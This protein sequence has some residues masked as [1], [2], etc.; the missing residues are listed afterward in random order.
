MVIRVRIMAERD[1][2]GLIAADG[3]RWWRRH[4]NYWRACLARQAAG[5]RVAL[6]ATLDGRIAG[7]A[8]LSWRSQYPAFQALDIPEIG[9]L[10]VGEPYRRRGVG[11]A[12]I[13]RC[14]RLARAR[15]CAAIGLGVGLYADYGSAQRLYIRLGYAL[16]GAGVTYAN[17]TL[18]VGATAR[19]DDEL[20]LWMLKPLRGKAGHVAGAALSSPA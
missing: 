3:G 17:H 18:P 13:R 15:G 19:L 5:E 12:I 10:R 4:E 11:T 20:I 7:Y 14:E 1:I 16:D 6:I 2:P 9:D 8:Y